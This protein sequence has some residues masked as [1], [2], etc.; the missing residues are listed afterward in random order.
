MGWR[1]ILVAGL[2]GGGAAG[3]TTFFFLA[4]LNREP[5]TLLVPLVA[6]GL[7]M[8][9][10]HFVR[11]MTAPAAESEATDDPGTEQTVGTICSVCHSKIRIVGDA[12]RCDDC[13]GVFHDHCFDD[14]DCA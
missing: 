11:L 5:P 4:V 9:A 12:A 7:G 14:H 8:A 13:R 10:G 1:A 3:A 6:V 2:V